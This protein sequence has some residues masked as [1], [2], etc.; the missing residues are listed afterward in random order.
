MDEFIS[1]DLLIRLENLCG[2][3]FIV[4]ETLTWA[5]INVFCRLS[6]L[7]EINPIVLN[8]G[9]PK[10]RSLEKHVRELPAIAAWIDAHPEDY[11]ASDTD[12][13]S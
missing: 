12:A 13:G 11:L 1:P 8:E 9:F 2:R 10:L 4:G 6:Q 5:D 7:L 3:P